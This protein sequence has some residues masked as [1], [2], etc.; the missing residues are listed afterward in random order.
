[1]KIKQI[2]SLIVGITS[3]ALGPATWAAPHGGG[4]GF[5]VGGGG[6]AGGGGARSG[7]GHFVGGGGFRSAGPGFSGRPGY[8]YG[9]GMGFYNLR[10]RQFRSPVSRSPSFARPTRGI[11]NSTTRQSPKTGPSPTESSVAPH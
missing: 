8:A 9:G 10:A 7:G 6:H 1:M 2:I 11:N 3:V 5:S 4:G